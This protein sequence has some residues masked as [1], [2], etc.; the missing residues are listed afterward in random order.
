MAEGVAG[1]QSVGMGF[2]SSWALLLLDAR[3]AEKVQQLQDCCTM[4]AS[5]SQP[6]DFIFEVS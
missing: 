2:V 4:D 6:L 3:S 5:I 1:G